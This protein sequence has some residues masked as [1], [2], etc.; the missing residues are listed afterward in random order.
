MKPAR[1]LFF[2]IAALALAARGAAG[3]QRLWAVP[4]EDDSALKIT[5]AT[6]VSEWD[7]FGFMPVLVHVENN[8]DA[9]LSW[10]F[11]FE[12]SMPRRADA[13]LKVRSG[14]EV[15][16][17]AHT[18]RDTV[19]Y[20]PGIRAQYDERTCQFEAT[21]IGPGVH[22]VQRNTLADGWSDMRLPV[23]FSQELRSHVAAVAA[24]KSAAE[25]TPVNFKQWPADWR[26]WSPF[27]IVVASRAEYERL[28]AARQ[29]ALRDWAALGGR[30]HLLPDEAV[31]SAP[32]VKSEGRSA[33]A[34]K[35]RRRATAAAQPVIAAPPP[36]E[37]HGMGAISG[38]D[39]PAEF[40]KE[41]TGDT[42][43]MLKAIGGQRMKPWEKISGGE[44]KFE[45]DNEREIA[46]TT[47]LLLAFLVGFGVLVGPVNLFVFAP[48]G[49]RHR[50]FFT[51]PAISAG[52][53]V[54]LACVIV[55]HDGFGG[56]GSRRAL[57]VLLPGENKA[58]VAQCQVAGTGMLLT[59]KFSL[60]DDVILGK[61]EIGDR[62]I[63]GRTAGRDA[64]AADGDWFTSRSPQGHMLAR[65]T[66]TRARVQL[67]PNAARDGAPAVQSS[68]SGTLRDFVYIDSSG[69]AWQ[70][71]A[72]PPGRRVTLASRSGAQAKTGVAAEFAKTRRGCFYARAEGG[73]LAPIPTL[74]TMTWTRTDVFV[75][76]EVSHE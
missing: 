43:G 59:K 67:V 9:G 46:V 75:T 49:K 8:T 36:G 32:A 57:I 50:L 44:W 61:T 60:P 5:V 18:S 12:V 16:V 65:I 52:A 45:G 72:V 51:M 40:Y 63:A 54:L 35:S 28:D 55:F 1:A 13:D 15:A 34:A 20:V 10:R 19:F 41:E 70:A 29:A 62:G 23:A 17:P 30:L 68:M 39:L 6:P 71:D 73:E 33:P 38:D 26:A 22:G 27:A 74:G 25:I 69:I 53:A 58:V 76:G 14:M 11:A 21:V 64:G 24:G 42:A 31:R 37:P 47:W 3:E 66:P 4:V 48:V 2:A 7:G 56:E